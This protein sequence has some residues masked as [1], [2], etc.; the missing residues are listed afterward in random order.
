M[1]QN[2][3]SYVHDIPETSYT[4]L[5]DGVI[6][7]DPCQIFTPV[8]AHAAVIIT[9][10]GLIRSELT[11]SELPQQRCLQSCEAI[12][13]TIR[14]ISDADAEINSPLLPTFLFVVARFKLVLCRT[15]SQQREPLFDILMH[16]INMC[17][18]RWPY[19]RRLDIVLRAAILEVD[20]GEPSTLPQNFW[21]LGKSHLDISEEMKE[22]VESYKTS[23]YVG[24]LNGP[25]V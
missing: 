5:A 14:G 7:F 22:W 25:Y 20:S 6:D 12:I 4:I 1:Y 24:S 23:L 8:L 3:I 21:N 18:R 17:G 2:L 15:M 11:Q 10:Q 13:N 19:A 16:I 9:Y